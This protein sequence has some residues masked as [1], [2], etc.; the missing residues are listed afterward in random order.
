MPTPPDFEPIPGLPPHQ[1]IRV[2]QGSGGI[3]HVF[4]APE[5]TWRPQQPECLAYVLATAADGITQF[6]EPDLKIYH[7]KLKA[8]TSPQG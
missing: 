5:K 6:P 3:T 2:E 4:V 8:L 1:V 7:Q